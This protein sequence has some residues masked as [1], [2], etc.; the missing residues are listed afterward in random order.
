VPFGEPFGRQKASSGI[1]LE[2][3]P[4]KWMPSFPVNLDVFRQNLSLSVLF[5]ASWYSVIPVIMESDAKLMDQ[6]KPT[7]NE[8]ILRII[9][10]IKELLNNSFSKST[11]TQID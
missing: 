6:V 7:V 9:S 1:V 2:S 10:R 4:V 11:A 8:D 5:G 3:L